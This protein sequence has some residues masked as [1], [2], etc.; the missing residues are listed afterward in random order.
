LS[1]FEPTSAIYCYFLNV[2]LHFAWQLGNAFW[3]FDCF[4]IYFDRFE[5]IADSGF[6]NCPELLLNPSALLGDQLFCSMR[7]KLNALLLLSTSRSA[8][9][10]QVCKLWPNLPMRVASDGAPV[11]KIGYGKAAHRSICSRGHS[12]FAGG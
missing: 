6:V 8:K 9:R 5:V 3:S 11:G 2:L 12:W 10:L 1:G 7:E 4:A